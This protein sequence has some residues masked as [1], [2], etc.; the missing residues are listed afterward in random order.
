MTGGHSPTEESPFSDTY[1][2]L[3]GGYL[4]FYDIHITH[5]SGGGGGGGLDCCG[6]RLLHLFSGRGH[7]IWVVCECVYMWYVCVCV[8]GGGGGS[9]P[10][11][12]HGVHDSVNIGRKK[13]KPSRTQFHER[14]LQFVSA[15]HFLPVIKITN[16]NYRVAHMTSHVE[17]DVTRALFQYKDAIL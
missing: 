16:I 12:A 4:H 9:I 3:G 14:A 8:C 10:W 13:I 6:W 5:L 11:K 17:V 15:S 7:V 1:S 2:G